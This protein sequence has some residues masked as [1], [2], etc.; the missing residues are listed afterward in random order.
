MGLLLQLLSASVL[1]YADNS[2]F[3]GRWY[4]SLNSCQQELHQ[5]LYQSSC[6]FEIHVTRHGECRAE[7]FYPLQG[8][9]FFRLSLSCFV[10]DGRVIQVSDQKNGEVIYEGQLKSLS[11]RPFGETLTMKTVHPLHWF[12]SR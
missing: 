12:Y 9:S 6:V 8:D 7:V 5:S 1:L 3:S 10:D 2:D 11:W 4:R